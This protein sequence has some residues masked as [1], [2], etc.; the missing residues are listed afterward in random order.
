VP[1]LDDPGNG[2]QGLQYTRTYIRLV[3]VPNML[4]VNPGLP[5]VVKKAIIAQDID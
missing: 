1:W 5:K 2:E 3:L 4:R